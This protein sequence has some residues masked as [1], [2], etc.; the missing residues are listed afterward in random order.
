MLRSNSGGPNKRLQSKGS[1]LRESSRG[2]VGT[3]ENRQNSD[4]LTRQSE[5]YSQARLI[6]RANSDLSRRF[7]TQNSPKTLDGMKTSSSTSLAGNNKDRLTRLDSHIQQRGVTRDSSRHHIGR[8]SSILKT[9]NS[10]Y[11]LIRDPSIVQLQRDNSRDG[12]L[13]SHSSHS[14]ARGNSS[15][16]LQRQ[17]S[18]SQLAP[19]TRAKS[20][21]HVVTELCTRYVSPHK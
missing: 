1:L 17:T 20:R 21:G 11:K 8:E 10:R 6:Y 5:D 14:L 16:Q 13:R 7:Q 19:L 12:L 3:S 15:N 2:R 4:R 18:S 9:S